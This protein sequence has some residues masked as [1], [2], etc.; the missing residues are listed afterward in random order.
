MGISP[1]PICRQSATNAPEHQ[2]G[3]LYTIQIRKNKIEIIGQ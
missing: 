1:D 2:Q 3:S